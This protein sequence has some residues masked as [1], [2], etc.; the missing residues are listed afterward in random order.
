[1]K[2]P[3]SA[4]LDKVLYE[5]LTPKHSERKPMTDPTVIEKVKL[6]VMKMSDTC[7]FSDSWLQNFKEPANDGDIQMEYSSY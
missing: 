7:T 2:E 1:L 6:F 4:Q 5:W 3:K